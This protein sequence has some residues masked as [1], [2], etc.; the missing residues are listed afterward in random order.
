MGSCVDPASPGLSPERH[1]NLAPDWRQ[2]GSS[3]TEPVVI[4]PHM[5]PEFAPEYSSSERWRLIGL[6]F[7]L[8]LAGYGVWK[9]WLLPRLLWFAD[10]SQCQT[11]FGISGTTVL[12]YGLFVGIPIAGAVLIAIFTLGV[13]VRAIRTRR[14][15]PLGHK[16]FHRTKVRKGWPAVALALVPPL[17]VIYFCGLAASG[18][19]LAAAQIDRVQRTR[20]SEIVC[21]SHKGSVPLTS[22]V[23]DIAMI[24]RESD[25]AGEVHNTLSAGGDAELER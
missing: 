4:S 2:Y 8:M 13:S 21:A 11:V 19:P 6:C 12:F 3:L 24:L 5:E 23:A 1:G 9:L 25:A 10:N 15:P 14:Y 17:F 16:V 22:S 18:V 20:P 7:S